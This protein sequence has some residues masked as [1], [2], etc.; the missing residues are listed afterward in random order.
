MAPGRSAGEWHPG[1]PARVRRAPPRSRH[2]LAPPTA[3]QRRPPH[4]VVSLQVSGILLDEL[5]RGDVPDLSGAH[6]GTLS[7]GGGEGGGGGRKG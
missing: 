5:V 1:R 7:R 2:Q 6:G 4:L 3:L